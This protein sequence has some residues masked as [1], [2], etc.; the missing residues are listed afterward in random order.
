MRRPCPLVF[1][2]SVLSIFTACASNPANRPLQEFP[3]EAAE[4]EEIAEEFPEEEEPFLVLPP[5]AD[6]PVSSF[7][8][9]WAYLLDGREHTL[10]SAYPLSDVGYFGAEVNVYGQLVGVPNRKNIP[11]GFSGR[12][13]LVVC[14]NGTALTHFVLEPGSAVRKKFIADLLEAVQPFDGLQIDFES[15]PARDGAAFRSFLAELREGLGGRKMFTIALRAR[16]R[17]LADDVYDYRL[18]APLVDRILI[19][20]YDE[21][22]STSAPGPIASMN[23]CR[24]VARYGLSVIPPEK[25]ILGVPFYGRTWGSESTF[26]AFF[27]SGIE[28]IKRENQI[29]TVRREMG[30]PTFTYEIPVTVTVYYEDEYSL[31]RRIE[32]YRTMGVKSIGFWCLGQE[33]PLIWSLLS[34]SSR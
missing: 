31:S 4:E 14:C 20:A 26:R 8:E 19:M 24:S 12:V 9:I 28:R 6:L 13:H 27:H 33:T 16:T 15:V 34:L 18:I 17:S 5:P 29:T 23:W 3:E 7:G 22:W 30:I 1:L 10:R 2:V 11:S 32:M 25:L 21:H